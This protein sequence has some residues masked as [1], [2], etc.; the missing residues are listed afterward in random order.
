[1]HWA[2]LLQ[3]HLC[4]KPPSLTISVLLNLIASHIKN[5]YIKWLYLMIYSSYPPFKIIVFIMPVVS[6]SKFCIYIYKLFGRGL[7][8]YQENV[9][10][11]NVYV[12]QKTSCFKLFHLTGEFSLVFY[13]L[14]HVNGITLTA[15]LKD[16][17]SLIGSKKNMFF[18][19]T[20]RSLNS[21]IA[22]S[23]RHYI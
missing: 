21:F 13:H 8:P 18:L 1:M 9:P 19:G 16:V 22:F 7:L 2:I 12:T 4:W 20:Q 5:N 3:N 23:V 14:L 6:D 15:F 11:W 17:L 10:I